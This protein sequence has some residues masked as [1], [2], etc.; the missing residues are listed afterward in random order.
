MEES[1]FYQDS[2]CTTT[3]LHANVKKLSGASSSSNEDVPKSD[4]NIKD[5]P[6]ANEFNQTVNT[7]FEDLK[8][9]LNNEEEFRCINH[10]EPIHIFLK[11]KP[12]TQQEMSNQQVIFF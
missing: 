2:N 1:Y 5:N 6:Q 7:S 3:E 9:N 10:S 8:K 4:N 11:L 12:L